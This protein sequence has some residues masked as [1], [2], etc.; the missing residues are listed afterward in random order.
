MIFITWKNERKKLGRGV[1][2]VDLRFV[3]SRDEEDIIYRISATAV[4]EKQKALL[5]H[6]HM[7]VSD[8][9]DSMEKGA[10]YSLTQEYENKAIRDF[11]NNSIAGGVIGCYFEEGFPI[12][13]INDM[14]LAHLGFQ[15][16]K[17]AIEGCPGKA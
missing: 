6:L 12:Y 3:L 11:F 4:T 15:T 7:S 13:F 14:M 2:T 17:R 8:L 9:A 10:T 1:S 16:E 5:K